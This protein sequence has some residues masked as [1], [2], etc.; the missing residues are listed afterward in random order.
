VRSWW[1]AS[2]WTA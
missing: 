1:G 2:L